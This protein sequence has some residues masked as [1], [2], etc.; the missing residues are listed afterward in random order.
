MAPS[1][2]LSVVVLHFTS[3]LAL[4]S[5]GG[6]VTSESSAGGAGGTSNAGSDAG[7]VGGS[8]ASGGGGNATAQGGTSAGGSSGQAG[9]SGHVSAGGQGGG[10]LACE[11]HSAIGMLGDETV[12]SPAGAAGGIIDGYW[13]LFDGFAGYAVMAWGD[14]AVDPPAG[15]AHFT[16]RISGEHVCVAG[17][18]WSNAYSDP[19]VGSV[20]YKG[21]SSL[22]TCKGVTGPISTL[23]YCRSS[24]ENSIGD[25]P[26]LK[27]RVWGNVNGR[28]IDELGTS[29]GGGQSAG[30]S[31]ALHVPAG[32]LELKTS[33]G[34]NSG[35]LL[36]AVDGEATVYCI[37]DYKVISESG[38]VVHLDLQVIELGRCPGNLLGGTISACF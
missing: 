29:I 23:N 7:S 16:D 10:A 1:R 9:G 32:D 3:L 24:S 6:S 26:A 30:K 27:V 2:A 19:G 37:Q 15:Q 8:E 11:P 17:A 28:E 25:C 38:E 14:A 31:T 20:T 22:G 36:V 21:L 35:E 33:G 5:C 4:A 18:Y 34:V 13:A 12:D